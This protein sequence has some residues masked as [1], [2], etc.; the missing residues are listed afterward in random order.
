MALTKEKEENSEA[1]DS[2]HK[3]TW[4]SGIANMSLINDTIR[5]K[6]CVIGGAGL[7][8]HEVHLKASGANDP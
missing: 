3:Q 2:P 5:F 1:K 8:R 7:P 4:F 6:I